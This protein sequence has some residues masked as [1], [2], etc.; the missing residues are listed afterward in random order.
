MDDIKDLL[1]DLATGIIDLID[2]NEKLKRENRNLT[3]YKE[4]RVEMDVRHL[5]T[6]IDT[7]NDIVSTLKV[8][9][10]RIWF[11]YDDGIR[12]DKTDEVFSDKL[13]ACNRC[14]WLNENAPMSI[15]G[16]YIYEEEKDEE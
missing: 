4:Q 5:Q 13:D 9:K 8:K 11:K 12:M 1:Y 7:F 16:Q 14:F 10:Y 2:E 15:V 3:A 6:Q